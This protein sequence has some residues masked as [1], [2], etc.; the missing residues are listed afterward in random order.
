MVDHLGLYSS[1]E[2]PCNVSD[3]EKYVEQRMAFRDVSSA[4]VKF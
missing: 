2:L 4:I 3:F 1:K